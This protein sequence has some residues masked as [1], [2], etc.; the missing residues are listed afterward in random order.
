MHIERIALRNFKCFKEIDIKLSK[1]TLLTGENSSGKSSLLYGLLGALQTQD[2]P[3]FLSPN[4]KYVN[5]GDFIEISYNNQRKQLITI[6]LSIGGGDTYQFITNWKLNTRTKM[7]ILHS[8]QVIGQYFVADLTSE[9]N[10]YSL[11]FK[12]DKNINNEKNNELPKALRSI[13][14]LIVQDTNSHNLRKRFTINLDSESFEVRDVSHVKIDDLRDLNFTLLDKSL[15]GVSQ[16]FWRFSQV[17]KAQDRHINFISSFRLQPERMYYQTARPDEKIGRLGENYTDQILEWKVNR[18]KKLHELVSILQ[19][20]NLLDSIGARQLKGG[21]FEILAKV[22]DRGPWSSL[23][24]VGFGI[25]QFVPIIVADLQ[26]PKASTLVIAQ[27]ETHLHPS[28]QAALADY[29]I[30]QITTKSK[31]YIIETHSE[32]FINRLRLSIVKGKLK[33]HDISTYFFE[34]NHNGSHSH[35]IRLLPNG[36]IMDAPETFFATYMMDVFDIALNSDGALA[37]EEGHLCR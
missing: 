8:L 33:P 37:N 30:D 26:L 6:E 4:G 29:I 25:S 20:L 27:P 36:S 24:D 19:K 21:R 28:A 2:F 5:M 22:K 35:N 17:F 1:I 7:P 11:S 12:C 18:S 14:E 34:N 32:Y 31:R 16:Y 13:L 15:F 3:Y 9:Q 10:Y 23:A